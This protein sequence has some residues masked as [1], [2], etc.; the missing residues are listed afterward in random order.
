MMAQHYHPNNAPLLSLLFGGGPAQLVS[1]TC[2]H[3]GKTAEEQ[4]SVKAEHMPRLQR[5]ALLQQ[6]MPARLLAGAQSSMQG[7]G[8]GAGGVDAGS[9]HDASD[10]R[11]VNTADPFLTDTSICVTTAIH[12]ARE[13][14]RHGLI[15]ASVFCADVRLSV[16]CV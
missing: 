2:D 5:R 4:P 14:R 15:L 7:A 10:A 8:E 3:C 6:K 11:T 16:L 13:R 9:K 12:L 1:L